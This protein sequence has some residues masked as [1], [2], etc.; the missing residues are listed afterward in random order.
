MLGGDLVDRSFYVSC[1]CFGL[2]LKCILRKP[3]VSMAMEHVH[4]ALVIRSLFHVM[5]EQIHVES[6]EERRTERQI[7][8]NRG[9][10]RERGKINVFL[11][12][13]SNSLR[14]RQQC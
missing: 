11:K 13:P 2:Q 10:K 14:R 5:T 6:E 7:G 12:Y 3:R 1:S 8:G 9:I 4:H